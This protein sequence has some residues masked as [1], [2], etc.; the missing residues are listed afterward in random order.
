[1][2]RI[3]DV[4]G[5][6]KGEVSQWEEGIFDWACG[7]AQALAKV[8]LERIDEA[9]LKGRG[10]GL[11]VVGFR[12]HYITTLFGDISIR[13]RL[14]QDNAGHYRFLLDEAMGLKKRSH[15]SPKVEELAT[16]LASQ[17]PS[18]AR[19]EQ[20]LRAVLPD[21]VSH[22]TIH[23]LV[24]RVV[25]PCIAEE[26]AE[27]AAVFEEGEIPQSEGRVVP[28]LMAEADGVSI[29]LQR[30]EERRGEVKVGI[31]YEGWERIGK[32]RYRLKEKTSYAGVM[33]GGRFW[34]GFS[35]VLAKRYD[36][37][38]AGQIIVG[39][40]GADWAREGAEYL[41]GKFQLDRFHLLRA[42]YR[43]L[44]PDEGLVGEVYRACVHSEVDKADRILSEVQSR[45]R[46]EQRKR[47]AQL[48]G[49]L[50]SNREGLPDY[51]IGLEAEGLRGLGAIEGNVDKLIAVRMKKRGMSW[52]KRGANRMAR[53]I[54][55]RERGEL[56]CW[57]NPHPGKTK[58]T[59]AAGKR[60]ETRHY[61]PDQD[62][63]AWLGADLPAL[64]GSHAQRPWA[65][66][67]WALAHGHS[68]TTIRGS[69]PTKC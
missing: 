13:R 34:E 5:E 50:L 64:H 8:V 65:R 38:E 39:S 23:R 3:D 44:A 43:G 4:V 32:E 67:L 28:Y 62:N 20:V 51:R 42:L 53:L 68:L 27:I 55:L 24:G 12:E 17:V 47:L 36:L 46:G 66:A 19:C 16:F 60:A 52:T 40:D 63:G 35:L 54:N 6:L 69:A 7:L 48:R 41:G 1:V 49:Y 30:E 31:A 14:Y 22:T 25:D 37:S 61:R 15:V 58:D 10:E 29:A 56:H 26:E 2:K 11:G 33:D 21:G 45:A 18:F 9:L 57:I 59:S